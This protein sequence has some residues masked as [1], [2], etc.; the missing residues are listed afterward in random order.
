[1]D[2]PEFE[3]G[4]EV[5]E[6]VGEVMGSVDHGIENELKTDAH[7]HHD[8]KDGGFFFEG[9]VVLEDKPLESH[10]DAG[11]DDEEHPEDTKIHFKVD[12]SL[13]KFINTLDGVASTK[14]ERTAA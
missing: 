12:G 4:I 5:N 14:Q 3:A 9:V 13:L 1:M 10:F 8:T 6:G 2:C 11:H 7:D